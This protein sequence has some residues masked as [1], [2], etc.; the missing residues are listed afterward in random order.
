MYLNFL[1]CPN[2]QDLELAVRARSIARRPYKSGSDTDR[3]PKRASKAKACRWVRGYAPPGYF[4]DFNSLKTPFLGS[5]SYK[6]KALQIGG[7]V[8]HP[9]EFPCCNGLS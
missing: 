9:G 3:F 5:E 6:Q 7:S 2:L 8:F 4:W 1:T